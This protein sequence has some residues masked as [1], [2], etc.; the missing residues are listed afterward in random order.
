M[1][2]N[3]LLSSNFDLIGDADNIVHIMRK[4]KYFL[5]RG[6]KEDV[7]VYHFPLLHTILV[8]KSL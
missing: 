4:E 7:F 3:K 6:E 8:H 1:A 5:E 2:I